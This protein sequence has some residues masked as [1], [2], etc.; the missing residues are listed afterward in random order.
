VLALAGDDDFSLTW[1]VFFARI[2]CVAGLEADVAATWCGFG[3]TTDVWAVGEQ[4]IFA[5]AT[6][7]AGFLTGVDTAT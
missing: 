4:S 7:V 6:P 5:V 2:R 3:L 1:L